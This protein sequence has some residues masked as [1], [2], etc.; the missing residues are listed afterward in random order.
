MVLWVGRAG[1]YTLVLRSA[2]VSVR[3]LMTSAHVQPVCSQPRPSAQRCEQKSRLSKRTAV[4]ASTWHRHES[5]AHASCCDMLVVLP[6]LM[7][8]R[9]VVLRSCQAVSCAQGHRA[10]L[11][12][13]P[14]APHARAQSQ[15]RRRAREL[16]FQQRQRPFDVALT[17]GF[18]PESG[19][20]PVRH[21]RLP[22]EPELANAS[23]VRARRDGTQLTPVS[24]LRHACCTA[25]AEA[26]VEP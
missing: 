8:P 24:W 6:W 12:S 9:Q 16:R 17:S 7:R 22:R 5:P 3:A 13:R 4:S 14:A 18:A 26:W 15:T 1:T 2:S 23:S 20:V 19:G 10:P 21:R 11:R 25:E